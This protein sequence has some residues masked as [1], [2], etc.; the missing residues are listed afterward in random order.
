METRVKNV[1]REINRVS[2]VFVTLVSWVFWKGLGSSHNFL[3][4]LSGYFARKNIPSSM[5]RN[6]KDITLNHCELNEHDSKFCFFSLLHQCCGIFFLRLRVLWK[7]ATLT[8][9]RFQEHK[10]KHM[11]KQYVHLIL[12]Y[13]QF[14]CE[15]AVF[16]NCYMFFYDL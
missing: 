11:L 8:P 6:L 2:R 13:R 4:A 5:H 1:L 14:L 15:I 10:Y 3:L 9:K 16:I 12:H 7:N